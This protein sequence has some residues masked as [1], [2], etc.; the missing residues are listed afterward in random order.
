MNDEQLAKR[1]DYIEQ[2]LAR[3]AAAVGYRYTPMNSNPGLP[4][5]VVQLANAGKKIQAIKL[6]RDIT[7][8][9]L[10]EAKDVVD[11]LG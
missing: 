11:G 10:K 5:E 7:G 3:I 2:H 1:L 4:P 8:A 9:G 6:Y